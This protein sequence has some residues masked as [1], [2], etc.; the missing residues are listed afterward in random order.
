MLQLYF[1]FFKWEEDEVKYNE[2]IEFKCGLVERDMQGYENTP[3]QNL[4]D[5]INQVKAQTIRATLVMIIVTLLFQ[6]HFCRV[7]YTHYKRAHLPKSKG[8]TAADLADNIE[9]PNAF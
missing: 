9:M 8:G 6:I 7:I 4:D 2:M 5:C 1:T 3:Y